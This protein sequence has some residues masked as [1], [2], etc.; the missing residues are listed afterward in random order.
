M[1]QSE[2]TKRETQRIKRRERNE[3]KKEWQATLEKW[4]DFAAYMVCLKYGH[5][6]RINI[7]HCLRCGEAQQKEQAQ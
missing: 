6:T 5:L 1:I 7:S 4:S 2:D 3:R